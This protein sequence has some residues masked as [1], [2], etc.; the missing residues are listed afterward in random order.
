[1]LTVPK[2]FSWFVLHYRKNIA[3]VGPLNK[4]SSTAPQLPPCAVV[5]PKD[6]QFLNMSYLVPL[7]LDMFFSWD[8]NVLPLTCQPDA[9]PHSTSRPGSS[10]PCLVVHSLVTPPG[11]ANFTLQNLQ[12]N[13]TTHRST[14]FTSLL[15]YWLSTYNRSC[16]KLSSVCLVLRI[17]DA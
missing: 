13:P 9:L 6:L 3:H 8:W 12:P 16:I 11:I 4:P 15:C 5:I 10:D 17:I 1:M 2:V 7:Y 14:L